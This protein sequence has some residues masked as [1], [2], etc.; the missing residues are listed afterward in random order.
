[1]PALVYPGGCFFSDGHPCLRQ[2]VTA[3]PSPRLLAQSTTPFVSFAKPVVR[4]SA[5]SG[6]G[7]PGNGP[8]FRGESTATVGSGAPRA[9]T[10]AGY[11]LHGRSL[12]APGPLLASASARRS[13]RNG[14]TR[15]GTLLFHRPAGDIVLPRLRPGP[16]RL[17]Q[18]ADAA[19]RGVRHPLPGR[20]AC[21]S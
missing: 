17:S 18:M 1:G 6:R 9:G 5:S 19:A 12:P 4:P 13:R 15:H 7:W 8:S 2:P 10:E 21:R 3:T 16:L 20:L 14:D 11:D